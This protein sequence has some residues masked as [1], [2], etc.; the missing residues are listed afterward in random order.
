MYIYALIQTSIIWTQKTIAG[1]WCHNNKIT[2]YNYAWKGLLRTSFSGYMNLISTV[3][4]HE[5]ISICLRELLFQNINKKIFAL[6]I[7]FRYNIGL[8]LDKTVSAS[9]CLIKINE[10]SLFLLLTRNF[11]LNF[12][13]TKINNW[14]LMHQKHIL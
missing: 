2:L 3:H 12:I 5:L 1:K 4:T 11:F 7:I 13:K 9:L 14:F 10:L 8:N 6:K